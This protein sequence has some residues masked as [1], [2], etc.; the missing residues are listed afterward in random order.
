MKSPD[1]LETNMTEEE[2]EKRQVVTQFDE[3]RSEPKLDLGR[4]T[5]YSRGDESEMIA[6]KD[7]MRR[8]VRIG[9]FTWTEGGTLDTS[10]APWQLYFSKTPILNKLNN[11]YL[12]K[13]D[14]HIKIVVNAS[15][16]YYG[17]AYIAY[18]PFGNYSN[19]PVNSSV[20]AT[21]NRIRL[22]QRPGIWVYPQDNQGGSMVLPYFNNKEWIEVF[23][24]AEFL[25]LGTLYIKDYYPLDNANG[26]VGA[27]VNI[28][29]YAWADNIT[30]AGPT[31][32]LAL[33]AGDEYGT[34]IISAPA[35][36]IAN[37]AGRLSDMPVIGKFAT[38][39]QMVMSSIGNAAALFGYTKLPDVSNITSF[40]SRP[41]PP[42]AISDRS[43][44]ID[45]LTYDSKNEL[46]IDPKT[47]GVPLSDEMSIASYITRDSYLTAFTWTSTRVT[48]DILFS[49]WVNPVLFD[50]VTGA[51]ATA[52]DLVPMAHMARLFKYWRGDIEIRLKIVCSKYHRGR[53]EVFWDPG[54]AINA[55]TNTTVTNF[56]E[57]V[58]IEDN[59]DVKFVIP[60]TQ[61][62]AYLTCFNYAAS[63]NYTN[64]SMPVPDNDYVNGTFGVKVL[65]RQTSP[66]ASSDIRILV[67]VRACDNMEFAVPRNIPNTL[68][69]LE[70]QASKFDVDP[71][72]LML[73]VKPSESK[74]EMNLLYMGEKIVSMRTLF[75]RYDLNLRIP[76]T[77]SAQT[78]ANVQVVT[79]TIPRNVVLNGYDN[80]GLNTAVNQAGALSFGYNFA[81]Q[82]P[83][84]WLQYSFLGRR[85]SLIYNLVPVDMY[86]TTQV[87]NVDRALI[88]P[89]GRTVN[90]VTLSVT[91][92][93]ARSATLASS[94][95]TGRALT[96]NKT[97]TGL[98]VLVPMYSRYKFQFNAPSANVAGAGVSVDNT[99][100]DTVTITT[101]TY[102]STT[103]TA[104]VAA[105]ID[106]YVSAGTD[107]S[108]LFFIGVPR[109]YLYNN[110]PAAT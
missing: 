106:V 26:V 64:G 36:A 41:L 19:L 110:L 2:Q 56:T 66:V 53:L 83:I 58:D 97:Q 86:G 79:Y 93:V 72:T 47:V 13:C 108:L 7:F 89:K 84:S 70:P 73:G 48:E 109:V 91:N 78:G 87:T 17:A 27:G 52:F 1:L 46:T 18:Q 33:Q 24:N 20:D 50:F 22:S 99:S 34:G 14:L 63:N 55:T 23:D 5:D 4:V 88:N 60:Y 37:F 28:S 103:T 39:T 49:L 54:A 101:S 77:A 68:S 65:N 3:Q 12:L 9:F 21:L 10:I 6:L 105:Y 100:D 81:E 107:F 74:P 15:P 44:P 45:K 82:T 76:I 51:N 94:G 57:I 104:N 75:Q 67:F 98:T 85:G 71:S 30:L 61:S 32:G 69:I 92:N 62:T 90:I 35:S 40:Y 59:T 38:A 96:I 11:F 16:F 43:V 25:R 29:I 8:P 102:Y 42:L 31:Q 95:N 80:N